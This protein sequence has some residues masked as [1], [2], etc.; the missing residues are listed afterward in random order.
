MSD[1]A[2]NPV[3]DEAAETGSDI[4]NIV[5]AIA[6]SPTV[7]QRIEEWQGG[8]PA[9]V[10]NV[11][12]IFQGAKRAVLDTSLREHDAGVEQLQAAVSSNPRLMEEIESHEVQIADIIAA[13]L[14]EGASLTIYVSERSRTAE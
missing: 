6:D 8:S 5:A 10:V 13:D 1:G 9:N 2:E 12:I 11:S 14:E 7:A 3:T 4:D